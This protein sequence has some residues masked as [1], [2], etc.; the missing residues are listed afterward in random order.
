VAQ[1]V[2]DDMV[3]DG[4]DEDSLPWVDVTDVFGDE[5]AGIVE[6]FQLDDATMARLRT[7]GERLILEDAGS[8]IHMS[9]R[10]P[11]LRPSGR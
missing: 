11:C 4:A 6:A 9:L 10:R 8:Y 7:P 3:K 2:D 5:V 1:R